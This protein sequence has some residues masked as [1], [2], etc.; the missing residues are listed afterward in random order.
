MKDVAD[1]RRKWLDEQLG[2]WTERELS[3][4][5]GEL[6]RYNASLSDS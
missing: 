6:A 1:H 2:D 4:F 3:D 5:V